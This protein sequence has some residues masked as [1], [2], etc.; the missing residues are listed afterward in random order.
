M[1]DLWQFLPYL[2]NRA[3]HRIAEAFTGALAEFGLTL[4]M[5]RVMAALHNEGPRRLGELSRLTTIELS[6]LSRLVGQMQEKGLL[7]RQ[8]CGRD[9]RAVTVSLTPEGKATTERIIPAALH[10]ERIAMR[11]L[12]EA[13]VA[14]LRRLLLQIFE[15]MDEITDTD[16]LHLQ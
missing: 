14:L 13:E 16:H 1:F 5:W 3:G 10:Y 6:T 12:S 9:A 2:L 4:P 8:R 11:G 7:S 15:N